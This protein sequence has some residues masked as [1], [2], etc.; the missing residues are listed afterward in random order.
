MT[1]NEARAELAVKP[2]R[3]IQAETAWVWATRAAAAYQFAGETSGPA[4]V[5]WLLDAED[6]RHEALEHAALVDD[7]VLPAVQKFLGPF[8]APFADILA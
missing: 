4:S 6:L 2:L 7:H 5:K 3:A 8:R 1:L